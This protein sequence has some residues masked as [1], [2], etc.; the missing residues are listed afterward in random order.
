MRLHESKVWAPAT[1]SDKISILAVHNPTRG[2][3]PSSG[4]VKP[5]ISLHRSRQICNRHSRFRHR[6]HS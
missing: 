6:P 4:S 2:F 5:R 1:N 3:S